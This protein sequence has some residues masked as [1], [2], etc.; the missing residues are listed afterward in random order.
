MMAF[1]ASLPNDLQFNLA[2]FKLYFQASQGALFL[3]LHVM[4]H[5]VLIVLHRPQLLEDFTP[6]VPRASMPS[7]ELSRSVSAV[8]NAR[9]RQ[10]LMHIFFSRQGR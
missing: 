1:Y 10:T 9:V 8:T 5:S 3:L 6:D 2:N 4:F 7:V